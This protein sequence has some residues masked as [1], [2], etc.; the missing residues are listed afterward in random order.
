MLDKTSLDPF[1]LNII[2][3]IDPRVRDSLSPNQMEAIAEA[4]RTSHIAKRHAVDFRARVPLFFARFYIVFLMGR[5]QRALT[6]Q[7]ERRRLAW[8]ELLVGAFFGLLFASPF[9]LLLFF[10]LYFVKSSLGIDILPNSHLTDILK[11]H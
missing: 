6:R 11:P 3:R 1:T 10:I 2:E 7:E 4:I 8:T 9:L 5:D